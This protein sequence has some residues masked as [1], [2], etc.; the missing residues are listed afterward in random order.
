MIILIYAALGVEAYCTAQYYNGQWTHHPQVKLGI[1][2]LSATRDL[3]EQSVR[4]QLLSLKP[5]VT[6]TG[7]VI[8][9]SLIWDN[10]KTRVQGGCQRRGASCLAKLVE[11][12]LSSCYAVMAQGE[13]CL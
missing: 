9:D 3:I 8:A 11:P 5:N 1:A 2:S 7:G 10:Q 4:T 13:Q 12:S 6:I